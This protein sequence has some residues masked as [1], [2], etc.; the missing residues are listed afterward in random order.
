[1]KLTIELVPQTAWYSNVR[2]NVTKGQWDVLRKE[3]YSNAGY[4]CEIC[5][6]RGPKHP[7]ECHEIWDYNDETCEQTL[8]GLI[9][10]CPDCHKVKHM[11]Y[12]RISGN[13]DRALAH[14]AKVNGLTEE[15][16]DAYVHHCFEKWEERSQKE[17]KLDI[18]ILENRD[19]D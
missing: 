10:L 15:E 4:Q 6:G 3:C 17:W 12:A 11:G 14:L 16:A 5:K 13:Y 18:T 9:A 2:S 19:N 1:M 7:V 8:K